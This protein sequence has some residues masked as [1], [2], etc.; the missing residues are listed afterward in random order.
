MRWLGDE[1]KRGL[2]CSIITELFK[3]SVT[4]PPHTHT[5]FDNQHLYLTNTLMSTVLPLI[6]QRVLQYK[7]QQLKQLYCIASVKLEEE[8]RRSNGQ[9]TMS[10]RSKQPVRCFMGEDIQKR[11]LLREN[12]GLRL[13]T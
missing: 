12:V 10:Q 7:E 4:P 5:R 9:T 8:L 2:M 13:T 11:R 6:V 3:A 1:V